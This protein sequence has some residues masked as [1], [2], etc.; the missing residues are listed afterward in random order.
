LH[1]VLIVVDVVAV[2]VV[3]VVTFGDKSLQN[4]LIKT[5]AIFNFS[6]K[7]KKVLVKDFMHN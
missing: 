4:V 1:S 7:W 3:V 6:L 2:D 5:A